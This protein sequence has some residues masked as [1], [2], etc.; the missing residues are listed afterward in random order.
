MQETSRYAVGIDIGTTTVRC[1]VGHIDATT[2][3]PTIVGVGQAPNSGMRKG[4]VANLNGPARAIDD[5][6]GEA[7][8]MSGY[9]VNA[10]SLSINGAHILSTKADG[11]IAVGAMDHE[12]THEDLSRIEEVATLGKVPANREIL[13]V[14]PH[15]YRLDGQ[16]NIKDPIGMTGTRLEINANVVSAL[17]P[18]LANLQ[19]TAEMAKVNAR[20]I[21]PAVL[22]AAR[23]VLSEQQIENGVAVVDIG[24]ATTSVAVFEEG[25]LQYVAVIPVGGVNITNDLAIGLKT[26][27][28]IAEQVKVGHAT[29]VARK[30]TERIAIKQDK[31]THSFDSGD[32]DEIVEARLEEI[33]DAVHKEL[34]KAGR[35]GQL[36]SGVVLT[37]GSAK[38]KGMAEFAKEKLGLAARIGKSSGYGGVAEN[39]EEPQYASVVGLMLL[40]AQGAHQPVSSHKPNGK[41]LKNAGGAISKFLDKFKA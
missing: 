39:I 6:L 24:G 10:A 23:A 13:E 3:T 2:G 25:D 4:M 11:M 14:V 33:F 22:A 36:P 32:V 29:A 26:D 18:H 8:R 15:S 40:D 16:D 9:Q 27:P 37:G 17:A 5:A 30:N 19:K 38:M 28:E 35:A 41:A 1:V 7:E 21:T 34:K 20:T 12:I 31:E